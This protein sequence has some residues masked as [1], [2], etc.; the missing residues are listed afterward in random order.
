MTYLPLENENVLTFILN[1]VHTEI[2]FSSSLN[3]S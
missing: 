2:T 3:R 1:K